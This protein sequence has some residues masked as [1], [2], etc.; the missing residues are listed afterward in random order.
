M[1]DQLDREREAVGEK[2]TQYKAYPHIAGTERF[3]F[4]HS[5][6]A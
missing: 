5:P 3:F 2:K 6:K 1:G 4:S